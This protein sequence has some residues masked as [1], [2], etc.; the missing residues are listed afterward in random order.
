MNIPIS[1]L[2]SKMEAELM[3]AKNSSSS[4][5]VREKVAVIQSLCEI[6]LDE[7]SEVQVQRLSSPSSSEINHLELQK[8]MG[9]MST[10]VK[11]P[12]SEKLV[13]EEDA[14]GDSLFDF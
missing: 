13:K 8:M 12:T 11:N 9:N 14:N 1:K 7:K 5:E 2:L 4:K 10:V 6:I 3:K